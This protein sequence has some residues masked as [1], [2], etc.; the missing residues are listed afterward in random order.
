MP[1]HLKLIALVALLTFSQHLIA[2]RIFWN[3][4]NNNRIRFGTLT[5]SSLSTGTNLLSGPTLISNITLD[6]GYNLMFF[7]EG[8]GSTLY[9]ANYNGSGSFERYIFGSMAEGTD[10]AY[11]AN[12]GGV[13]ATLY[14]EAGGISFIPETGGASQGLNLGGRGNDVFS[15][16]T[17]DDGS[18]RI[19]FYDIDLD[20]IGFVGFSDGSVTDIVTGTGE[21]TSMDFDDASNRLAYATISNQIYICD[22]D[23]GNSDYVTTVPGGQPIS[24][25]VYYSGYN[26]VYFVSN[27]S[28]WSVNTDGS[29]L[30][31]LLSLPG[32][33]V[34]DL[35]VEPDQTLPTV[36]SRYP[37]NGQTGITIGE[38][39]T[40]DFTET[41]RKCPDAA[42]G[43]QRWVRIIRTSDSQ[44]IDTI[45]RD[46]PRLSFTGATLT[47]T[48]ADY[49]ESLTDYHILI[50]NRVVEDMAGNNFVG[51]TLAT[52]WAFTT[53][54]DQTKF[55][56]IG[57]GS[58]HSASTWSHDG[59][60]G[61]PA[62]GY[63]SSGH[64]VFIG[65]GHT[66]T[67]G[68]NATA[69]NVHIEVGGAL[70]MQGGLAL[71]VSGDFLIE[72]TLL[73]GGV[74]S[75]SFNITAPTAIPVFTQI[76][77]GSI[78]TA[79]AAATLNTNVVA[80]GGASSLNG[81]TL[82]LNGFEVCT[83]PSIP[84]S[85]TYPSIKGTTVTINWTPGGG[86]A[87]IILR[88]A[89]S[90]P[91]QPKYENLYAA[92]ANFGS[93]GEP[94]SNNFVVF[95][96]TGNTATIT[97]LT[98]ATDYE[99]DMYGYN[100][101]IGGCYSL[102]NYQTGSFTTCISVAA[103][104]NPIN[105]AYCTGDIKPAINVN[106]PGSGRTIN[107]YDAAAGG[108]LV[109]GDGTGGDGRGGVFIPAAASGTFYAETYDGTFNCS[110]DTRT[111][112]TLTMHPALV[113]GTPSANQNICSGGDPVSI[114]GGTASGGAG[115]GTY[116]YQWA[117]STTS[118]GP[119][120]DIGGALSANYDPPSGLAVTTYYIRKVTSATCSQDGPEVTVTV[121][122]PPT[123]VTPPANKTVCGNVSTSF[124]TIATGTSL[125]YQWQVDNGGVITN[126]SNGGVYSGALTSTLTISNTAGLNGFKYQCVV[127]AAASCPVTTASATLTVN[128]L[129]NAVDHT[130]SICETIAGSGST[131]VNLMDYNATVTG[132]AAGTNVVWYD[133]SGYS[134]PV[135]TPNNVFVTDGMIFYPRVFGPNSCTD[136]AVLTIDILSKPEVTPLPADKTICSGTAT[137]LT[138]ASVPAGATYAWTIPAPNANITGASA[139]TGSGINQTLNNTATSQQLITYSV[140][141]ALGACQGPVFT[142]KV[143]VDPIPTIFNVTGGGN[144]CSGGVASSI[145]LS[146]SQSGVTYTLL[147]GG[148]STGQ[149][150]TGN[151]SAIK[152]SNISAAGTYTVA[153]STAANCAA[154]MSGSAIITM[155]TVPTGTGIIAGPSQLCLGQEQTFTITGVTGATAFAWGLPAGVEAV[156]PSTTNTITLII[157]SELSGGT[158]TVTPSNTCGNGT[159]AQKGLSSLPVPGAEIVAPEGEIF[160]NEPAAFSYFSDV[161]LLS[162]LWSFGDGQTS[163][164]ESPTITY[165]TAGPYNVD[166]EVTDG[167]GCTNTIR[168]AIVVL[169]EPELGTF[170]VKNVITANGDN[171]NEFLYIENITEFE[172]EVIVIDRWGAEVFRQKNYQ[173][174]WDFKK[175]S[176]YLPAGNYV[177]VVKSNGKTYSRTI[178]VLKQK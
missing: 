107:W 13:F 78:E 103:P 47:I 104:A 135:A 25:I 101:T 51:F 42:V 108:N 34:T 106:S 141:P 171:A 91:A 143:F 14:F 136:D 3:E 79:G 18:E 122:N 123:I 140:T 85:P 148:T 60:G 8:N 92:N 44:P 168:E 90:T 86:Q 33:G 157:Q 30:T 24:S 117:S 128:P 152:F 9:Q 134:S 81:G 74:L 105:A 6:P 166:L 52:Q 121:V 167:N 66:V 151:G 55:Y 129:P 2:Q 82:N 164:D 45:D 50:G 109:P 112:V 22:D 59:H 88:E 158:L 169:P 35:G 111:A 61:S 83:A 21:V 102:H 75:G 76:Q 115:A 49:T 139:G 146:G 48:G 177:C 36:S 93:G 37:G 96:G 133:D 84:V 159:A 116:T 147:N 94:G 46:D 118:G 40:L 19:F 160:I 126:V 28:I 10:I 132:G 17:V 70:D 97:G 32:T 23:G 71:D 12:A 170:A 130:P 43:S 87:F 113:P 153:A 174:D 176:D 137:A 56:S 120:T 41:I 27:Q 144:V 77:Y 26:K 175:D 31:Q 72:G 39:F 80:T 161:T 67:L 69:E 73:N 11:S 154:N 156:S 145:D 142:Q 127:T 65:N 54:A 114:T 100:T 155:S 38:V 16:I 20:A 29:D 173:N 95:I 138:F 162:V 89:S 172:N 150:A 53:S 63:P 4:P 165:T 68:D 131:N 57:S 125:T 5:Y 58:W 7:T 15:C 178:T 99:I 119:Y 149:T 62:S 163:S 124:S 64:E 98:P 1:R 110:S